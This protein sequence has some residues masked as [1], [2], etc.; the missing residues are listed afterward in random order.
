MADDDRP[1]P[2][3]SEGTEDV[4]IRTFLIADVRGYT[5]F[6]QAR[7][8]EAAAKLAANFADIAREIVEARGGTLL[9]LRGDEALCVF[10]S[11]REAIRAARIGEFRATQRA[12]TSPSSNSSPAA[13]E[14]LRLIRRDDLWESHRRRVIQIHA[15]HVRQ[16]LLEPHVEVLA[17]L[18][19]HPQRL[20]EVRALHIRDEL[21]AG[22]RRRN[23]PNLLVDSDVRTSRSRRPSMGVSAVSSSAEQPAASTRLTSASLAARSL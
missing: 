6:T 2:G 7:G 3:R 15:G 17:R 16:P 4:H 1:L 5:L 23:E 10:A 8:D 18:D 14:P 9:E 13:A 11:A 20:V 21:V 22:R 12:A 19:E